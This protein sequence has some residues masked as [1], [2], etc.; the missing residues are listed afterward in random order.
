MDCCDLLHV[1]S[2]MMVY[3]CTESF[4]GQFADVDLHVDEAVLKLVGDETACFNLRDMVD[5]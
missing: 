2:E 5:A 3:E 4:E 1:D